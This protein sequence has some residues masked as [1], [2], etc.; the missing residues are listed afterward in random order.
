[1]LQV[2]KQFSFFS[3]KPELTDEKLNFYFILNE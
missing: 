2:G 3:L 1:M